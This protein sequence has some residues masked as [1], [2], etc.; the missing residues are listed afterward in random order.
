VHTD[1]EDFGRYRTLQERIY[2]LRR[3]KS[4]R[5]RWVCPP[6]Q[7]DVLVLRQRLGFYRG[8]RRWDVAHMF[9]LRPAVTALLDMVVRE[10]W[11]GVCLDSP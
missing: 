4:F 5:H 9:P 6:D 3:T 1:G 7:I 2:A 10:G 11:T 8:A